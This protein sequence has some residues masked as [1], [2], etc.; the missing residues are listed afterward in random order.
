MKEKINSPKRPQ[1][2]GEEIGNSITHGVGFLVALVGIILMYI[3]AKG[4]LAYFAV[5]FYSL[6]LTVL[7]IMS[8]LYHAFKT[9]TAVKKVFRVF[10]HCSIYLLIGGTYCP[11]LLLTVGGVKGWVY[12]GVQWALIVLGI[13]IKAVFSPGR[14]IA[15]HT[16]IY[17]L[18]GWSGLIFLPYL[19]QN[20]I[21][22]FYYIVIGVVFYSL[23]VIFF[24]VKFKYAHFIWHFFVILGAV[25][26]LLGIYLYVL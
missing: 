10:D 12:F 26:H 24:A 11:I 14:W 17:L 20:H 1:S 2:L 15:I 22:L 4:A 16:V 21:E 5:S 9:G 25:A 13:V 18:L 6:G 7:F 8:C 3:K 23:G 19:V